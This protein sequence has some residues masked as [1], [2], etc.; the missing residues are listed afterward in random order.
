MGR[1][2]TPPKSAGGKAARV[3]V[4]DRIEVRYHR[5][6]TFYP[7]DDEARARWRSFTWHEAEQLTLDRAAGTLE[8]T[9][10]CDSDKVVHQYRLVGR[11]RELLDRYG[12]SRL[13]P[14]QH[15]LT[16]GGVQDLTAG[17]Q[18]VEDPDD[19]TSYLI[20]IAYQ[21]GRD[22]LISGSYD[23]YGLPQDYAE[24]MRPIYRLLMEYGLGSMIYPEVYGKARR[25]AGELIYC[26]VQFE[27]AGKTYYYRTQ[28]DHIRVRDWVIVPTGRD[29]HPTAAKVVEVAYFAPADVP[30]PLE[31]TKQILRKCTP[32]EQCSIE[33]ES[34]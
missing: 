6:R 14:V 34:L 33:E 32:E 10:E 9:Y 21:K 23:R 12:E 25:R 26:R 3:K 1:S 5:I 29:D 17:Q 24:F 7:P 31:K 11:V 30:F 16:A 28:D 20:T 4:I 22:R 15:P 19:R 18:L 2:Q 27:Q 8:L 13:F